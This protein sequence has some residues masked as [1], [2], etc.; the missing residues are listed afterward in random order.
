VLIV[1]FVGVGDMWKRCFS[2]PN[3][4]ACGGCRFQALA[5]VEV[6]ILAFIHNPSVDK[7]GFSRE[8]TKPVN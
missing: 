7:K 3:F 4:G 6:W 8:G 2:C 5:E 1:V